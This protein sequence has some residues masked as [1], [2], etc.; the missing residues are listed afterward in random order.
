MND[1]VFTHRAEEEARDESILIRVDG[2]SRPKAQALVS[3]YDSGFMQ[4]D[5]VKT[6]PFQHPRL[7][8]QGPTMVIIMEHSR[9]KI[10]APSPLPPSRTCAVCR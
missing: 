2:A 9:P 8:Q 5:G 6:R 4:G 3:V 1:H 10:P 7:S